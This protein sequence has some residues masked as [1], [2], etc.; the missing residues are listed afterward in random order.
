M[1]GTVAELTGER[2]D[3]QEK[4]TQMGQELKETALANTELGIATT[5]MKAD[6][7]EQIG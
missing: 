1:A 7:K 6:F 3:I 4:Y 5:K 2:K